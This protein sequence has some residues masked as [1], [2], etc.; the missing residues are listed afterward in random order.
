MDSSA[1]P[2][3]DD[4]GASLGAGTVGHVSDKDKHKATFQDHLG[5][6]GHITMNLVLQSLGGFG[7]GLS[8]F[9]WVGTLGPQA[10]G[11]C[12]LGQMFAN[13]SGFSLI[14]GCATALD[15]LCAQEFGAKRYLSI[16]LHTQ[17]AIL[18]LTLFALPTVLLWNHADVIL[19]HVLF[20]PMP[21][22]KMAG[23][24]SR[25]LSAGLWPLICFECLKK[26]S[27][28]RNI[29]W[30]AVLTTSLGLFFNLCANYYVLCVLKKGFEG[31]A[32]IVPLQNWLHLVLYVVIISLRKW[33]LHWKKEKSHQ[34]RGEKGE[35][36]KVTTALDESVGGSSDDFNDPENDWPALSPAVFEEWVPFLKLGVPAA[37]SL[38]VEWGSFELAASI[39]GQ[40]GTTGL[41][42]HGVNM[43]TCG[44][45]YM[46]PLSVS[47]ATTTVAGHI[48]G[49]G[50]VDGARAILGIGVGIDFAYG[51][52]AAALLV[53]VLRGRWGHVFT[54]DADTLQLIYDTTPMLGLYT[55][56]DATKCITLNILRSGGL[57]SIT[58]YVNSF[59]CV[60]VMVPLG[61]FLALR[62]GYGL[63]GLWFAMSFSWFL[64]TC[65]FG[66]FLATLNLSRLK[67]I[68]E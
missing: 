37:L 63:A 29:V 65:F 51:A 40:L 34:R 54:Q 67:V 68:Q 20:I 16:G 11:A 13:I 21:I 43:S 38:F 61:W 66:Y 48:I 25:T 56:V 7:I 8:T 57:P 59:V 14:Y 45:L 19:H 27:Q 53:F 42:A 46:I 39:A 10:M 5:T 33:V 24:W 64:A 31:A 15:S 9:I 50:D 62:Q 32:S 47:S 44:L 22:A 18:I 28:A 35:Y 60:V 36:S 52:L 6:L 1:F 12:T 30:P 26:Y 3:E 17:R 49:S 2:E 4:S 23:F 55:V 58:L 41:S